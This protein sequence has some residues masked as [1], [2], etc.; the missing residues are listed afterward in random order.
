[1]VDFGRGWCSVSYTPEI[2]AALSGA[3]VR[4]LSYWRSLRTPEPL[5]RPEVYE[6]RSRVAYS[7]QDLLALRTFVYLLA[8]GV[9]L[10]RVRRAV[11]S[12]RAMGETE[13]LS[14]YV[15]VAVGRDVVWRKSEDEAVDLTLHPRHEVIARAIDILQPFSNQRD[16][17]VVDLL[18]PK[19]G[20]RID[21]EIRGGY[22]VIEGTRVPYDL[23]ASLCN[24]GMSPEEIAAIYPSV[25]ASAV[26]GAAD[27]A[28]YV[29]ERRRSSTAA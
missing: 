28:T 29:A 24:D 11:R 15:L 20:L 4:Q 7:F 18:I 9:P 12:L 21:P 27:F 5:L 26:Q 13:H 22:P 14:S 25:D 8:H 2:A 3:T 16:E 10:Q 23:V 19:P 1:M 17:V 6:P